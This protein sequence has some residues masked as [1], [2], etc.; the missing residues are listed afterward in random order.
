MAASVYGR[1]A[2][3]V[4]SGRP[5]PPDL[6]ARLLHAVLPAGC[7]ACGEPLLARRIALNLCPDCRGRLLSLP[8]PACAVCSRPL[9]DCAAVPEGFRCAACRAHPPA[10][11]RLLALWSYQPPIDAVVLALKFR[12]L[13]YLG[14]Q[15]ADE[16]FCALQA[17]L[18]A[19]D[20][21][22]PV[23]LHWRRR[24][25]RGYNQAELIAGPIAQRL[26]A[27]L[28]SAL[29]KRRATRPQS[30]LPR[31]ERMANLRRA[32]AVARPERI[33]GRRLLLIDDVATTG[34]TVDAAA[35]ALKAAGAA[36][37]V[38]LVVARTPEGA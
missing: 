13:D 11:E 22:V 28:L 21:V 35:S 29:A 24:L 37:V 34:A 18:P 27:P 12:R 4:A 32:F 1:G 16:V 17:Q 23:P 8:R 20:G 19:I 31:Q 26:G 25:M 9:V 6:L 36:S 33:V 14:R 30:R 38:A 10:F 2:P 7:L 5:D 3:S 15:L